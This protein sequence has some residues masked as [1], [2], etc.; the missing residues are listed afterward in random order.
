MWGGYI[1]GVTLTPASPMRPGRAASTCGV[2]AGACTYISMFRLQGSAVTLANPLFVR[3]TEE[4]LDEVLSWDP[5]HATQL[6]WGKYDALMKDPS[7]GSYSRQVARMKELVRELEAFP[8]SHL[9]PYER[10]DRDLAAH[11]FRMRVF[12]LEV[13]RMHERMALATDEIGNALFFLFFRDDRPLEER[14]NCMASRLEKVPEYLER[15]ME[16]LVSPCKL[17]NEI[18]LETGMHLGRFFDSIEAHST[19]MFGRTERTSRL[20]RAVAA[21]KAALERY[22]HW[23]EDTVIPVADTRCSLPDEA[24]S[25]CMRL[26]GFDM[27]PEEALEVGEAHLAKTRARMAEAARELVGSDSVPEALELMK[28]HHP[29]GFKEVLASYRDEIQR[30][31]DFV[32]AKDLAT[33]PD[34]EQ[35]LVIETPMFMRHTTPFAAQYEPGKF[36]SD[37]TGL[38]L[39]TPS[40]NLEVLRD[41]SHSL[42]CNTA[43]HEGYPGHHLQGIC[44]NTHPSHV[45]V[46][47]ASM[48]FGEGWALYCEELMLGQGYNDT[49]EGRL[50]QLSDLMF[51]VVRVIADVKLARGEMTPEE[52]ADMI[53]RETGMQMDAALSDAKSYTYC[54]TYYLS[55]FLGKM[56]LLQLLEDVRLAMGDRF[57]LK[58]FHNT[59]LY[60]GC[61]PVPFMR[62]E[63]AL[64]LREEYGVELGE[65]RE[66]VYDFAMRKAA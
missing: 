3:F 14:M 64:R 20:S 40:E 41:H 51:R 44:A 36:T 63:M 61:L 31:R 42:I 47:S 49:P 33:V 58:F 7:P 10:I 1:K 2:G 65:P 11:I 6:G 26:K 60:A 35:L 62:R 48:D 30:A 56:A 8:D 19:D 15:S 34:G 21:A 9:S 66:R 46:M 24:L 23:L 59:L 50:A 37:R 13:L 12:E 39:V 52:V 53:V 57:S 22:N 16:T 38:F 18:A 32:I 54:P 27:T 25:E 29:P 28:S 45:R 55:Y 4:I 17:W 5:A 43:V